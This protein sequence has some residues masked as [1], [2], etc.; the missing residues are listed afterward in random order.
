VV[1]PLVRIHT[2][3]GLLCCLYG[4]DAQIHGVD[5]LLVLQGV[6]GGQFIWI[7]VLVNYKIPESSSLT[8][9]RCNIFSLGA[10]GKNGSYIV[11][12]NLVGKRTA[13]GFLYACLGLGT[14]ILIGGHIKLAVLV[15][16]SAVDDRPIDYF[17]GGNDACLGGQFVDCGE[18]HRAVV[19]LFQ[20]W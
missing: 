19:A 4:D 8:G 7:L 11:D 9:H 12:Y 18:D 5:E 3:L 10:G 14:G 15:V 20:I 17:I 6:L 16:G 13:D 1:C 2:I